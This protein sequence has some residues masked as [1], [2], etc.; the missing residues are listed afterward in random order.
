V[1]FDVWQKQ[2]IFTYTAASKTVTS[3][4]QWD[5]KLQ[6]SVLE[7]DHSRTEVNP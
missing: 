2:G 5:G 3:P 1:G 6:D 7:D 4:I